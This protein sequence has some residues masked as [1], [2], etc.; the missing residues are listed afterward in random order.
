METPWGILSP[1]PGEVPP[2][3]TTSDEDPHQA[4]GDVEGAICLLK[5]ETYRSFCGVPNSVV[6]NVFFITL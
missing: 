6:S 3:T 4:E 5:D 2:E 1:Y